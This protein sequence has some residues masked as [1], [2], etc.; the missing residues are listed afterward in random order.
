VPMKVLVLG[1]GGREHALAW[2][3]S[4]DP[5]V[6]GIVAAPGNPGMA[7]LGRTVPVDLAA[8]EDV[9]ALAARE[10]ADLTVVG[11][12][13]PLERGVA[14][15]FRAKGRPIV[16]P[17]QAGAALE[18]SKAY[19]K[20][21]MERHRIPTARFQI[22]RAV[23]DADRAVD[24]LGCPVVVKA[25][26]LAGGKGVTVAADRDEAGA[27]IRAAMIDRQFGN[28]GAS[29]VIEECLTGPEVSFFLLTD[30]RDVTVLSTAQDHKRIWDDDRGPNTGGMGAFAPSPLMTPEMI[31]RVLD[32]IARPVVAGMADEGHPYQGFLYIGLML[33]PDGPKVIEFNVRL[34]DPEAQVVLPLLEGPLARTFMDAATGRLGGRRLTESGDRLIGVVLAARHYPA[35]PET[36]R[37]IQGLDAAASVDGAIVFHAGTREVD[38]RLVTAG[39]RVLTVVGRASSYELAIAKAY[40]AA[41]RI[42]FEGMQYRRDIGQKALAAQPGVAR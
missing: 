11:P 39:G 20:S 34:G 29:L 14:D 4:R 6:T 23:S 5:D 27:A 1:S 35:Q 38:G 13:A 33:T 24:E 21:F 31:A 19:A 22:A 12:E 40:E 3:L 30:G 15:L 10:R 17:S 42:R 16:G 37:E 7:H 25:D 26:G 2:R 36:G 9:L 41:S 8:P 28:A 18:C 32:R